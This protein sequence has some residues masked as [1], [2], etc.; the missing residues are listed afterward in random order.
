MSKGYRD[1]FLNDNAAAYYDLDVYAKDNVSDLLWQ[2][3][4]PVLAGI[5]QQLRQKLDR[6]DYLDF[7]SG[8]G[9]II[10]FMEDKVDSAT[11]I[12][13][14]EAMLS[15]ASEVVRSATLVKK[16]ITVNGGELEAQYDLITAFRLLLN[17]EPDLRRLAM[18]QLAKRLKGPES[19]VVVNT[20][21]NL[22]S[23]KLVLFPYHWLRA[24]LSR[25]KLSGYMTNKEA[26]SAIRD[27]GLEVERVFVM[28]F[29]SE[30]FLRV[31]PRSFCLWLELNLVKVPLLRR[32]TV[33]RI[34]VCRLRH[35]VT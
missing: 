7:A 30:K 10:S 21:G 8:T 26:F 27:A 2:L 1:R 23:Y 24:V 17:A 19:R 11:G 29:V 6:I 4:N 12:E 9:R 28:G 33:N 15:R 31:L 14:S 16:D 5:V 13:I 32:F 18:Q 22:W 25:R 34:F 35:I 3:E 20:H